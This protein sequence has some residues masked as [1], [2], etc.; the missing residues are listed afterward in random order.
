MNRLGYTLYASII[1]SLVSACVGTETGNPPATVEVG[2]FQPGQGIEA[3]EG[4]DSAFI[5][6]ADE[7]G[8]VHLSLSRAELLPAGTCQALSSEDAAV[9]GAVRVEVLAGGE[10]V[11]AAG[12]YCALRLWPAR[13]SHDAS[14]PE[15]LRGHSFAVR[16]YDGNGD[17]FVV[18]QSDRTAPIVLFASG[19]AFTLEPGATTISLLVD[20]AGALVNSEFWTQPSEPDGSWLFTDPEDDA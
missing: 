14:V 6:R 2:V 19:D 12:S 17:V 5:D 13:A 4:V 11:P 16:F 10:M 8:E 20:A 15:L 18:V 9:E 3:P 1:A 7:L